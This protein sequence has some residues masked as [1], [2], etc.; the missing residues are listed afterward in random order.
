MKVWPIDPYR[1]GYLSTPTIVL[2]R[3]HGMVSE[4][5]PQG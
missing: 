1:E 5:L 3:V 2:G 4:K